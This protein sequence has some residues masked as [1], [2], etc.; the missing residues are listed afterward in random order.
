M[1]NHPATPDPDV[2][3]RFD[4]LRDVANSLR[5][6]GDLREILDRIVDGILRVASC[7]RGF[8]ILKET[9][10]SFATYTGRR[11]D[12]G[13]WD[14]RDARQISGT[15]VDRVKASKEPFVASDLQGMDDLRARDSIHQGRIQSAVCLP[16]LSDGDDPLIGVIYAD[17]SFVNAEVQESDRSVLQ[18][19]SV[20]AAIAIENARRHGELKDRSDRLAEQNLSLARQLSREFAMGGMVSRSKVML[21]IFETVEKV[22]PSDINVLLQGASGTGKELLARAIHDKS[23]RKGGPFEAVNCAGIP[24]TLAQSILFGHRKGSYTS[25]D[26]DK[27][28]VFEV[29]DGGTLFLDEIGDLPLEIQPSLL[30]VLQ[31]HEVTRLGEDGRVRS[32]D[33]RIISATNLD[34]A[35]AVDDGVFRKDLYYRLNELCIDLPPLRDRREDILPLAEYFLD[36]YAEEKKQPRAQLSPDARTLLLGHAW[37]GNVRELKSAV[38]GGIVFQDSNRV[39]HAKA[40]E[41]FLQSRDR[42]TTPAGRVEGSLRTQID[43]V[44]E[45]LIRQTLAENDYNVSSTAKLLDISRQ[46]L[47]SKFRKYGITPRAE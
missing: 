13:E 33:V 34:L 18:L 38:E 7:E 41:R 1:P 20:Q 4:A 30:R 46:Q 17:S 14:E 19:F 2:Q 26:Y 45:Q 25:A 44:E 37:P 16:L 23:A 15:I 10:G 28:G 27:P 39:I 42:A 36:G 12:Q 9:D 5:S 6:A 47:Y 29:A 32:F 31:E 8:V 3:R 43:R 40:L 11:R 24:L 35:R 22:A 21:E